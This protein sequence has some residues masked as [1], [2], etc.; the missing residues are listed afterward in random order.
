M[1]RPGG[2]LA[3]GRVGPIG[4][5]VLLALSLAVTADA[6]PVRTIDYL[7]VEAN[8][9]GG[10]GGHAA[11]RFGDRVFH[12][13]WADGGVLGVSREDFA[14]FRRHYTL[15]E[16]RTIRAIR[17]PVSDETFDLVHAHFAG[18]RLIQHQHLQILDALAADR[19]VLEVFRALRRGEP[20]PPITVENAG[21]FV[22]GPL[23]PEGAPSGAIERL[24][25]RIAAAYGSSFLDARLAEVERRMETLDP[26]GIEPPATDVSMEQAP[27]SFYGFAQRYQD[28]AA[29]V[30]A[31]E[32]I[33]TGRGLLPDAYLATGPVAC[34]WAK[35]TGRWWTL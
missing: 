23:S 22:G 11:I 34:L 10:S 6:N 1:R 13:Q 20:A 5:W 4:G 18:R 19:R 33:R 32:V 12:F 25:E 35:A 29:A 16:N 7:Y 31:L 28:A 2:G 21:Y 15:L 26:H 30:Q 24:R 9:A 3:P 27:P 14:S 17:I 8:E